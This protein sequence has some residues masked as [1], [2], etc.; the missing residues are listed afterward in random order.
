MAFKTP[1]LRRILAL[2]LG[3]LVPAVL[4]AAD[5]SDSEVKLVVVL[6]RHG[7]RTPLLSTATLG[8]GSAQPWPKWDVPPGFLTA[9]GRQQMTL[10]GAYYRARYVQEGLLEGSTEHDLPH[11]YFWAD[12]EERTVATGES[13]ALGLLPGAVPEIHSRP[14]GQTDPLFEPVSVLP[15]RADEAL[16]VAA[17]KGRMGGDP[18]VVTAAYPALFAE[19]QRVLFG[20]DGRVPPGKVSIL[21]VPVTF[22]PG[23]HGE[24]VD[25]GAPLHRA[26][27]VIDSLLLEYVNG[28]PMADV[29][30]GRVDRETLTRLLQLHLLYF[31]L[32]QRTFYPAQAQASNLASHIMETMRQTI[33][34]EPRAGA[35]GTPADR[36]VFVIGHDTNIA[37]LGGLL[38]LS[39]MLPGTPANPLL[40]GGALVFELRR[41][42]S[43]GAWFVRSYYVSQSLEQM[44]SADPLTL[45]HP[46]QV[47]PIFIPAC[48]GPAPGYEAPYDQFAARLRQV[49]DPKFIVPSGT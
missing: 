25:M 37:N 39:W 2:L 48:S 15:G 45:E 35:I 30:W 13:L 36:M 18:S 27:S 46:P 34:G 42:R 29:G 38:G 26:E 11:I 17:V 4:G 47:A 6:S 32:T 43:D 9:H 10:M 41:H 22:A 8:T 23:S 3:A 19:L 28:M 12:S 31:D 49:M 24:L 14:L 16:A 21:T 1:A 44:R 40:P 5:S 20:G 33:G 7:V